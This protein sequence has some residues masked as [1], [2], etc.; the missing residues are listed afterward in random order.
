MVRPER[1]AVTPLSIW[2]TPLVPP[3]L[4]VTP[5]AGPVIVSRPLF[6]QLERAL[7]QCDRLG[8]REH[9]RV[10]RDRLGSRQ[11]IGQVD[12]PAEVQLAGLVAAAIGR[13]VDHQLAGRGRVWKAP[14]SIGLSEREAALVGGDAADGDALADGR[15]AGQQGHG[16]GRAAVDAQRGQSQAG[17]A[18]QDDV[19]VLPLMSPPEPPV[20]IRL[21]L[22]VTVPAMSLA[23]DEGPV[24]PATIV[25]VSVA[26]PTLSTSAAE[27]LRSC[28]LI[29]QSVSV[30]VP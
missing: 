22:P 30:A 18:G 4:I 26:V 3:P 9:G 11:D 20:P 5:A 1:V 23:A 10:E 25:S 15:A 2:K 29:V 7:R 14:M 21:C 8:V 12:G 27:R 17:Q 13:R 19:A 16:L 6:A 24:L 28:R